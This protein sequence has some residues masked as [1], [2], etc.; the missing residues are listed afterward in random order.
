TSALTPALAQSVDDAWKTEEEILA[1]WLA[2]L[3]RGWEVFYTNR[4][5]QR[6]W[7][8]S[9]G[10]KTSSALCDVVYLARNTERGVFQGEAGTLLAPEEIAALLIDLKLGFKAVPEAHVNPQLAVQGVAVAENHHAQNVRVA[11]L[12]AR[13]G[14]SYSICDYNAEDLANRRKEWLHVLWKGKNSST[15]YAGDWCAYCKAKSVCMTAIGYTMVAAVADPAKV[16]NEVAVEVFRRRG[17]IEKVID[18]IKD[19]LKALPDETLNSLG[20]R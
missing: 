4:D 5:T 3:G 8:R 1:D 13:L 16:T 14:I 12:Q 17:T 6:L 10:E 15:A 9:R 18:A 7:I 20:L 11:P 19:R 2:S